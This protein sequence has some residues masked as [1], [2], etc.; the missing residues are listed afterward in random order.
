[1]EKL[2]TIRGE[3]PDHVEVYEAVV[4]T[5]PEPLSESLGYLEIELDAGLTEF[6]G[7]LEMARIGWSVKADSEPARRLLADPW[8]RTRYPEASPSFLLEEVFAGWIDFPGLFGGVSS[9]REGE[10]DASI[11]M[12]RVDGQAADPREF[13]T[14]DS[15]YGLRALLRDEG[16]GFSDRVW[17][18]NQLDD[19]WLRPTELTARRYAE[20]A[21]SVRGLRG[22][23]LALLG[24]E[25]T[26]ETIRR[27]LPSCF[28]DALADPMLTGA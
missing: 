2:K 16:N 7:N 5:E 8:V 4:S 18:H 13:I 15:H 27:V 3:A 14:L 17:L 6:F 24:T 19:P 25:A 12:C 20:C 28:P 23:P 26:K 22:W 21:H 10:L 11:S 9:R 1:M